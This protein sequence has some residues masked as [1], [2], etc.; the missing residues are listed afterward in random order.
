M[1]WI[2]G[3]AVALKFNSSTPQQTLLRLR[4]FQR[5]SRVSHVNKRTAH[6][7]LSNLY[8]VPRL[9]VMVYKYHWT[10]KRVIEEA[11]QL[12]EFLETVEVCN[13]SVKQNTELGKYVCPEE[14]PSQ[15]V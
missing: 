15:A 6:L 11:L 8:I 1:I 3:R 2:R 12:T 4:K 5:K 14:L 10:H 9:K 13:V 7:H